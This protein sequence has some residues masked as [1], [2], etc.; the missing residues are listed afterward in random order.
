MRTARLSLFSVSACTATAIAALGILSTPLRAVTIDSLEDN[1][2]ADTIDNTKWSVMAADF[3]AGSGTYTADTTTNAD[4]LTIAGINDIGSFWGGTTLQSVDTFS[5]GVETIVTVDRV[6]LSGS[7]TAYRSSLWIWQPGGQYLHFAHNVGE[8][9]W[10]YNPTNAGGGTNIGALDGQDGDLGM[11]QMQLV[12][13]PQGG[14]NAQVEIFLDGNLATTHTFTNWNNALDFHVRLS[15]MAR[16]APNDT[17]S[18]VFDNFSASTLTGIDDLVLKPACTFPTENDP[19]I[20][21]SASAGTAVGTLC[22][23]NETGNP[24]ATATFALVAGAGDTN[25]GSYSIDGSNLEVSGDLSGLD[26]VEHSV[27]VR[28]TT[29]DGDFDAELTFTVMLDMDGDDL[30]DDWEEM[31]GTLNDFEPGEDFDGDG[32]NDEIEF[33][34]GTDPS[35]DDSDPNKIHYPGIMLYRRTNGLTDRGGGDDYTGALPVRDDVELPLGDPDDPDSSAITQLNIDSEAGAPGHGIDLAGDDYDLAFTFEFFDQDGQFSFTENFDDRCRVSVTPVVGS[36]NLLPRGDAQ[37]HEDIGWNV[38]TFGDYDF[39]QGGWFAA[40]VWLVEDAGGAQ[41]AG[42]LGFGYSNAASTG[43]EGDYGGLGYP[44]GA[45]FDV[46]T[47]GESFGSVLCSFPPDDT[48]NDMIPDAYELILFPNDPGL[49]T[50]S[51]D[52]DFDNDNLTDSEEWM[53]ETDPTNEDTDGDDALDGDEVKRMVDGQPAPTDPLDPD[54]DDDNLFDGHETNTEVYMSP[55][56]TGTDPLVFDSD[57]D[58]FGDGREVTAGT[59]PN[60]INSFPQTSLIH[61]WSFEE[62]GGSGT[63]LVDSVG[64]AD[65]MIIEQGINDGMVADGSVTLAGGGKGESDY[66]LLP[67]PLLSPLADATVETWS[68]QHST[69]NWSRVFSAAAGNTTNNT[70][71]MSFTRGT[72][73]NQNELRWNLEGVAGG[74]N[75]TMQD[76]GGA[77][78]N[79]LDTQVHWVVTVEDEGGA[80]GDTQVRVYKDGSEVAAAE[81]TNDLSMLNDEDIYLGRSRWGDNTGNASWEEFRIYDGALT[82]AEVFA[83]FEA[84]PNGISTA[85]FAITSFVRDDVNEL[86]EITFNSNSSGNYAIDFTENFQ[87]GFWAEITD[88]GSDGSTT[89][90]QVTFSIVKAIFG[91]PDE[92]PLPDA[93]FGRVRDVDVQDDPNP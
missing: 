50:L 20:I 57:N 49:N 2:D 54:T 11:K 7:G 41:S 66:V 62:T 4:Q 38:R 63:V 83:S 67:G 23:L 80:S 78:T 55:T 51:K 70:L 22:A 60:D 21:S 33:K 90:A 12:Y 75:L 35:V 34:L 77:P 9:G 26:G 24:I 73:I 81:T 59:D 76:F 39:S 93:I 30:I 68:T 37:T 74:V 64:G 28:A 10:Q 17:V 48:D 87:E 86:F 53:N 56:N 47:N 45:V 91:I 61:R 36:N 6:L 8:N 25:N 42:G 85:P 92:D 69:Q 27:R 31:F 52:G 13:K 32:L 84:G 5:S 18:A 40:E 82:P 58:S 14:S 3:E 79:P 71:H 88:L 46:D 43:N 65:G 1:F 19:V 29:A 44:G 16:A 15:G 89:T 72:N